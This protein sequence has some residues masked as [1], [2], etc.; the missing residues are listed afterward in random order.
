MKT[1]QLEES[2]A[3][4][5]Y[6][7]AAPEFKS[8]L[9]DTFGKLFF[10]QKITDRVKTFDDVLKIAGMTMTDI[11]KHGGTEDEIAYRQLKLIVEVLNEGWTPDWN[12]SN[13]YKYYPW[14]RMEGQFSLSFVCYGCASSDVGSRLCFKTE[15]LAQHAV[16]YFQ[17]I[18]KK[19]FTI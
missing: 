15:A 19:Y 5:L 7:T 14:W 13:E 6:Q 8:M 18:Y 1:L 11:L 17:P 12:N 9:E 2:K 3:R 4:S 10:S 16:K